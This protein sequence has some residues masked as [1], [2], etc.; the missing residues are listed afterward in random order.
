MIVDVPFPNYEVHAYVWQ[1]N[2]GR[3]KLYLLDT[4]NK[5]NS[6]YDRTITHTLYGGDWENR[7][8]QEYLLGIGGMLMLKN[9]ES[10][11][12]FIIVMKVMPHCAMCSD[13]LIMSKPD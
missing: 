13:W 5:L 12:I 11:K 7:L 2:V 3:I 9:W 4:D 10:R 8:K 6:E 1:V